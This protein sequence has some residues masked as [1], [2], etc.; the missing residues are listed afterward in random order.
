MN[1]NQL[2]TRLT[3]A[4]THRDANPLPDAI[5]T[6]DRALHEIERRMSMKPHESTDQTTRTDSAGQQREGAAPTAP[7]TP[8]RA[9][10]RIRVFAAGAAAVIIAVA[11]P[12]W[13]L[14]GGSEPEPDVAQPAPEVVTPTPQAPIEAYIEAFNAKDLDAVME[15]FTEESVVTGHPDL[16]NRERGPAVQGL[17]EI[18]S[19]LSNSMAVAADVDAYRITNLRVVPGNKVRWDHIWTNTDGEDY[20]A[21]ANNAVVEDGKILSWLYSQGRT[22]GLDT[23]NYGYLCS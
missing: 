9:K 18:R 7:E 13:L 16:G 21:N 23:N 3:E 14:N 5:W 15:L 2:L 1:D 11:V 6:R 22:S 8:V 10:W 19:L 4:N 17:T 20:C 12:I